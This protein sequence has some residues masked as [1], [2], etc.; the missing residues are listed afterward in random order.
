MLS[1]PVLVTATFALR[2]WKDYVAK[3][4]TANITLGRGLE[5]V[6]GDLE[7]QGDLIPGKPVEIKATI[8]AVAT[9]DWRIEARAFYHPNETDWVGGTAYLYALVYKDHA[10]VSPWP[11]RPT[12]VPHGIP[13]PPPTEKPPKPTPSEGHIAPDIGTLPPIEIPVEK[14]SEG[15][16]ITPKSLSPPSS[17]SLPSGGA[18]LANPLV[19]TGGFNCKISE[20]ALPSPDQQRS[21]EVR[22]SNTARST[23]W[24]KATYNTVWDNLLSHN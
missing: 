7:W 20:N 10:T 12:E 6:D 24:V 23:A 18:T 19:V 3:N 21:D 14:P 5:L 1:Q 13:M 8:R 22:I 2:E 4:A 15:D 17:S 11:T 16:N 9:G